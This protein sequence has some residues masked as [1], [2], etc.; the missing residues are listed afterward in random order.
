MNRFS[1][2]A[3]NF[4]TY[5]DH[6][7]RTYRPALKKLDPLD[8]PDRYENFTTSSLLLPMHAQVF[9]YNG[10]VRG[11]SSLHRAGNVRYMSAGHKMKFVVPLGVK[12]LSQKYSARLSIGK[13]TKDF[14]LTSSIEHVRVTF[15]F[16]QGLSFRSKPEVKAVRVTSLGKIE[17]QYQGVGPLD[18]LLSR[19]A[20]F[21]ANSVRWD[22][23]EHVEKMLKKLIDEQVL[24]S[25]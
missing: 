6:I 8:L 2:Q 15:T 14:N 16:L 11:I 1:F 13:M 3:L 5:A 9:F 7:I 24:G 12:H 21:F 17:V 23:V 10:Q 20:S 22:L 25:W 19:M 4:N 18:W